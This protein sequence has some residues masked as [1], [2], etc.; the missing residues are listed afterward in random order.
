MSKIS[1][2][3]AAAIAD[4]VAKKKLEDI[5][6]KNDVSAASDE[7]LLKIGELAKQLGFEITIDE[8]KDFL[9]RDEAELDDEELEAAAGGKGQTY[10]TEVHICEV[11][12]QAGYD[13]DNTEYTEH[14]AY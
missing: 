2:F 13:D 11:G 7:Q 14:L 9:R 4:T 10:Y 3:Y 6:G 5:L 8:A 1:D 12:G